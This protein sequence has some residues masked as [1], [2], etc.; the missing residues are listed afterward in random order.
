MQITVAISNPQLRLEAFHLEDADDGALVELLLG[1]GEPGA[2]VLHGDQVPLRLRVPRAGHLPASHPS[3]FAAAV[4]GVA[5]RLS[6]RRGIRR[7]RPL[8]LRRRR[9]VGVGGVDGALGG[10]GGVGGGGAHGDC[11]MRE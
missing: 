10:G 3:H 1:A 7:G 6:R 11:G 2:D 5:L 9:R 8:E 4:S